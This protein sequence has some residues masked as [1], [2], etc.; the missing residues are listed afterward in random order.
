MKRDAIS[1]ADLAAFALEGA[2]ATLERIYAAFPQL[3]EGGNNGHGGPGRRAQPATS[4]ARTRKPMSAA[5]K[6]ALSLAMTRRWAER[7]AKEAKGARR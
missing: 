2:K 1:Q 3:R 6:K 7:K 4:R 5:R